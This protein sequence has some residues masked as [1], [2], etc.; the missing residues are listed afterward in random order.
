M[1]HREP[2][3]IA[4]WMLEHMTSGDRDEALMGD[5]LEV[6][7]SGRSNGWYWHQAIAACAVSWFESLRVRT[8]LLVFALLWSMA[9]PAWNTICIMV[10]SDRI[11]DRFCSIFG[12][13]WILPALIAWT[14]LH[15]I[16]LWG[17]LLIFGVFQRNVGG[18]LNSNKFKRAFL[19]A[20]VIFVPAY[21][22]LYLTVDLHWYGYFEHFQLRGS[23]LGQIADLRILADAIRIP[24]LLALLLALWG[25]IPRASRISN[26]VDPDPSAS[27]FDVHSDVLALTS[28]DHSS[29]VKRFFVL[30]VGAG[31][32][33]A[34]IAGFLLCRLPESQAPTFAL[35]C[36][37]AGIYVLAGVLAGVGGTYLY[38]K[39]PA[40]PFS[41]SEPLPFG[42]F[43][44]VCASGW[45]W[46]P[47][48]VISSEQLSPATAIVAT[49]GAFALTSGLR[50]VSFAVFA[51]NSNCIEASKQGHAS[52]FAE[53]L[54][55]P[56]VETYG[57]LISISLY[58]G[59]AAL[60]TRSYHMAA[61]LLALAASVFAWKKTIPQSQRVDWSQEYKRAGLRLA[62]FVIPALLLTAWTLLDGVAHRNRLAEV[63]AAVTTNA[64]SSVE[65]DTAGPHK[66]RETSVGGGGYE[67]VILWPY[68]KKELAA[69][70][71]FVAD[72]LLAPGTKQP[73][74]IRFNGP[75]WYLQ[76][77]AK[78]PGSRAHQATGT[79]LGFDIQSQNLMPLVM[80][81]HQYLSA[82]IPIARCREVTVELGNRDNTI[83]AI[84]LG[85]LLTDGTSA[86]KPTLSL[87]EQPVESTQRE[88]FS[89]KTTPVFET[90]H[91]HVPADARMRKFNEITV[92]VLPEIE[93]RY[94]APKIA[95]QQFELFP[96]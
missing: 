64:G 40:S 60:F 86:G 68:P 65:R 92:L 52:L 19:L 90:L 3:P 74:I 34:M 61:V 57:Y 79:P 9:A 16:F 47:A 80:D 1:S 89:I 11:E 66:R 2:P 95:I 26:P 51:S 14:I 63:S 54:Y 48:M 31:L 87:G 70:P 4:V 37:Q 7:R 71:R 21:G 28:P 96:R 44:L 46:V 91:F 55:P 39:N 29:V 32:M 25:V 12:P 10:E 83:G 77:P 56:P 8:P 76:P 5:L 13:F 35:L 41:A 94:E 58:A 50:R 18:T 85:V 81:A 75:Y 62:Q 73:L 23:P 6:F 43:A 82:A 49:I 20:P 17:G 33:N 78:F 36:A 93:H 53:S 84:S 59:G 22:I 38:W 30:M 45:I 27:G 42:L 69:P 24:Y 15:S 72:T 67:S 88:H